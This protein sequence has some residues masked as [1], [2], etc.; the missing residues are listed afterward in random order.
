MT[1]VLSPWELLIWGE[2]PKTPLHYLI[3]QL[4]LALWVDAFFVQRIQ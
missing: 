3:F 2:I 4:P 1:E